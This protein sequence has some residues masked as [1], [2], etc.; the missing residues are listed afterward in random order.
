MSD[1]VLS[2]RHLT[3]PLVARD[4]VRKHVNAIAQ[5]A[6][7]KAHLEDI[8]KDIPKEQLAEMQ[9]EERAWLADVVDMDKHDKLGNP[10]E[11]KVERGEA[12]HCTA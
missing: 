7:A 12:Y 1:S 6:I 3:D 2:R 11:I 8:T 10:Y 9:A 5:Y 4:L